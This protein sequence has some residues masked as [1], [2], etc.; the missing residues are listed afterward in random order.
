[1]TDGARTVPQRRL[2]RMLRRL[3]EEAGFTID[4]VAEQL[5]LSPST[6]SRMETA[7]VGVRTN[8]LRPLLDIYRSREHNATS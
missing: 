8:D 7:Q 4:E 3:R 2:A 1:M 5:D 6:I